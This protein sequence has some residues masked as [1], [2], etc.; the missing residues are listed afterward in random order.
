MCCTNGYKM[1]LDMEEAA[2][3]LSEGEGHRRQFEE[4]SQRRTFVWDLCR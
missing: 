4:S 1:L 3:K 2:I